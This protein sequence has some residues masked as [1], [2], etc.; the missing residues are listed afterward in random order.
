MSKLLS[1]IIPT[2]NMEKYL[3]RCL[4]SLVLDDDRMAKV[5]ILVVNDG[6]K[7]RSSE[8]AHGFQQK[9]PGSVVVIDKENGH[10]GSCIN[11]GLQEATATFVKILDAD[12]AFDKAVFARFLDFLATEEVRQKA[13]LI[14]SD[15]T[16]VDMDLSPIRHLK[17]G[18]YQNPFT[19]D[20]IS[21]DDMTEWFIHGITYRTSLL[22]ENHYRQVE[23]VLYSDLQWAFSPMA[24][25][26][27]CYR[28]NGCLYLYV[29]GREGQSVS[30]T[31]HSKNLG[32]E[33]AVVKEA[34]SFYCHEKEHSGVSMFLAN[35]ARLLVEHIYQ[36][37]LLTLSR[38]QLP[39][40][41]LIDFDSFVLEKDPDLHAAIASYTTSVGGIP[42][43][44]IK[45]WREHNTI[46]L[47]F[48]Q[49]L[50]NMADMKNH[51]VRYASRMA[52]H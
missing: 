41:E 28:F 37:Y 23:R 39:E 6:S 36:L 12:D 3:E 52:H 14:L 45:D 50:Y 30:P 46:R 8:I 34:I 1:L 4:S 43:H 44:P 21:M 15:Y 18:V 27:T 26:R 25:V 35:R 11:R 49:W 48:H 33:V 51:V 16:E 40:Q 42:I 7:D 24:Y 10:Y 38:Y 17:Y 29:H 47:K 2:Y 13:D 31:V 5:E 19:L 20:D 32:N 22:I 9:Y